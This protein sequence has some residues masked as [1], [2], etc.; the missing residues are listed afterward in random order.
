MRETEEE[1]R[2][3]AEKAAEQQR[4]QGVPTWKRKIMQRKEAEVG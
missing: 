3:Q 1:R 2:L 4:W